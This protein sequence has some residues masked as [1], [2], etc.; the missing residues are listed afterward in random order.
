MPLGFLSMVVVSL[1]TPRRI[2]PGTPGILARLHLP[3]E[4][5]GTLP[6]QEARR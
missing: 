5:T 4:F 6:A 1:A 2:P 3:E